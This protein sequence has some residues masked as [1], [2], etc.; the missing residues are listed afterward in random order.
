MFIPEMKIF[1]VEDIRALDAYTIKHEP[2][3]SIDLMERASLTFVKWFTEKFHERN[4]KVYVFCGIGNNGGDGLAVA[5]L[6]SQDHYE[7]EA[8]MLGIGYYLSADCKAN[9]ERLKK[10]RSCKIVHL[11]NGGKMP[12]LNKDSIIIDAIFGS[13][14]S[15]PVEGF[16]AELINHLNSQSCTRVAVDIPS[17]M[18]ADEHTSGISFQAHF[19]FSFESPKLGFF[20]PENAERVGEWAYR[21]I[22][23]HPK[24]VEKTYTPYHYTTPNNV[25]RFFQE[26]K[27]FSHKGTYGH[28]LMVVGSY[29]KVGAAVLAAKAAIRSGAGLLTVHSPNCAYN[30]LQSSVPEAMV[31]SDEHEHFITS[32]YVSDANYRA[33]GVG[34]GI[35]TNPLTVKALSEMFTPSQPPYVLDADALNIIAAHPALFKKIPRHSILTPHPKEFERLFGKTKNDFERI[36]LLRQKAKERKMIIVLKGAHTVIAHPNGDCVFNGT[37]NPGMATGGS[38]DVLTGIITGLVAQKYSYFT[39]AKIGVYLHGLAG[40]I[41]VRE[42]GEKSLIA[43]DIIDYLG[44]AF[45]Q[46]KTH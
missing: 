20:L 25:K 21:S 34:C 30:I 1:P 40:D 39:A 9:L 44:K 2:I 13:G 38:G 32:N 10:K 35:G 29:G 46:L 33:V 7:V 26:R 37:G 24:F 14:L 18:F 8:F 31:I 3:A 15:R 6:L 28:A 45:L 5:R 27:K 41:A 42:L 11:K 36:E 22:G 43:S 4:K 19:T 12:P 16:W 17:G 23:L